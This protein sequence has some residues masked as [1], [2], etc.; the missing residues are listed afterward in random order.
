MT[1]AGCVKNSSGNTSG[2]STRPG[3]PVAQTG[4]AQFVLTDVE[5]SGAKDHKQ[6]S[7]SSTAASPHSSF[8]LRARDASVNLGQHLNHKVQLTG[9]LSTD[10]AAT[11]GAAHDR[12]NS[13]PSSS[14]PSVT[15]NVTSLKMISTSCS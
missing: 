14:T 4:G 3:E 7:A 5:D 1:V 13:Q 10:S 11:Q 9:T 6:S 15:F 2:G 12:T 8:L